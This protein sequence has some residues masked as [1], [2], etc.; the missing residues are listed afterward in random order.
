MAMLDVTDHG[1]YRGACIWCC[2]DLCGQCTNISAFTKYELLLS[3]TA[4]PDAFDHSIP[5]FYN[6]SCMQLP[7]HTA[8]R[9]N[10]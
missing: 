2:T 10:G 1:R 6:L 3:R 5:Q 7:R 9:A 4:S 8:E